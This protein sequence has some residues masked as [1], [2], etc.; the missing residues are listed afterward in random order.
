MV[1]KPVLKEETKGEA[2]IWWDSG[3]EKVWKD[4]GGNQEETI[5]AEKFR[6]HKAIVER[7]IE[8]RERQ[9]L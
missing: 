2:G 5:S 9:A 7:R 3:A 8:A 4:T 6:K 1:D